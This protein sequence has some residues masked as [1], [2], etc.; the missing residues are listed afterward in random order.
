M[1][2]VMINATQVS[3]TEAANMVGI[4]RSTFYRHIGEKGI[5]LIKTPGSHPKV[6]VSELIRVYGDKVQIGSTDPLKMEQKTTKSL[7][8]ETTMKASTESEKNA[9][10]KLSILENERRREREQYNDQIDHL[11]ELLKSEQE[12]RRK[13]TAL[14]T[15]QTNK[16]DK[17]E[18]WKGAFK[19]LE[20]RIAS[21]D[22]QARKEI[23]EIKKNSQRQILHY[24]TALEAGKKQTPLETPVRLNGDMRSRGPREAFVICKNAHPES[25]FG[26]SQN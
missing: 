14:L 6:D 26:I 25:L 10:E 5:S 4:Q 23:E 24:K 13:M 9:N 22:T 3:I 21:Q 2:S 16:G 19:S 12:E 20:E 15:D 18:E 8:D 7:S 17:S 11:R 1:G